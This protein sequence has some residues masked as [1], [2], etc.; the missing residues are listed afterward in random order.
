MVCYTML[1]IFPEISTFY[2]LHADVLD[3]SEGQS[4]ELKDVKL[5]VVNTLK[6]L[7]VSKLLLILPVFVFEFFYVLC[8]ASL[9]PFA[10]DSLLL[11]LFE[12]T[13][14]IVSNL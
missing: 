10:C 5:T 13:A 6:Y 11:W 7:H 1:F 14:S 2:K 4:S 8:K 3:P 12:L 9:L